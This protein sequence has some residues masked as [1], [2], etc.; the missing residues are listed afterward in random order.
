MTNGICIC[1]GKIENEVQS[2][3]ERQIKWGKKEIT[4]NQAQGKKLIRDFSL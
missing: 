1:A 4:A 2:W 3:T